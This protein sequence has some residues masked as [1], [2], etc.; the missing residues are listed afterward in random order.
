MLR[1]GN[2]PTDPF[3]VP[4]R[5]ECGHAVSRTGLGDHDA[6]G[7]R[8]A[9]VGFRQTVLVAVPEQDTARPDV[10][11][12]AGGDGTSVSSYEA[13]TLTAGRGARPRSWVGAR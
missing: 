8:I 12:E 3:W 11:V 13:F 5:K 1:V 10:W 2:D 9:L 4:S 6:R 7:M